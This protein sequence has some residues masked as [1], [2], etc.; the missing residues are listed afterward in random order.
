ME[1]KAATGLFS[2]G[3]Q[4]ASDLRVS[5]V[6]ELPIPGEI[7]VS[8][9]QKVAA[10][11]SVA[12]VQLPGELVILRIAEK[13]SIQPEDVQKL[14][15]VREGDSVHAGDCL[16]EYRGLFGLFKS[17]FISPVSG[18]VELVSASTGHLGVR[19]ASKPLEIAAYI[20]GTVSAIK[21]GVAV[22]IESDAAFAQGIFG[23]GSERI[24]VLR[25][26]AVEPQQCIQPAQ[27]P[28]DCQGAVLFGGTCP[29]IEVLRLAEQR[30]AVGMIVGGI[31]DRALA[32]Y[33]GYDLGIALTGDEAVA[34]TLIVSDGFGKLPMARRL[35]QLLQ[36]F[37]G[38]E[39]SINGATQVR[40]GAL[41]PE[42]IIPHTA[43][44]VSAALEASAGLQVGSLVRIIRVPYFGQHARVVELPVATEQLATGAH[45]RV[46]RARLEP[47]LDGSG[48]VSAGG[49]PAGA[50]VTVPRANVELV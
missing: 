19:L 40:A 31:D 5:R 25:A 28:Q 50:I 32:Q 16:L 33:L 13:L 8:L 35:Q 2:P 26:I 34:M 24:G 43:S 46:L 9:G 15:A 39:C 3:L 30:G 37:E 27:L 49:A 18:S 6:R 44:P 1:A 29:S 7:C 4:C 42:I 11:E 38:Q 22:T 14:L 17:R 21:P 36:R 10:R 47:Q 12:R 41:R 20:S 45:A 48:V 23:I